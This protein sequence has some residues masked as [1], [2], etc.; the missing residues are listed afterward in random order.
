MGDRLF[1]AIS[2][3]RNALSGADYCFDF[4]L[5][6]DTPIPADALP[7][8]G[9]SPGASWSRVLWKGTG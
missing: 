1:M 2:G 7:K 3:G 8:S 6:I 4:S 9:P 5:P